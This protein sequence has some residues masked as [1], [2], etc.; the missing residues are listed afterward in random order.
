MPNHQQE[1]AGLVVGVADMAVGAAADG[2]ITTGSLGSCMAL[3][4]YDPVAGVG[5][6]LHFMLPQPNAKHD[7]RERKQFLYATT[8]IPYMLRR[9]GERG[10]DNANLVLVAAGG[11][12]VREGA[13]EMAIGKRNRTMLR[14]VL[15]KMNLKLAAED[16]GGTEARTMRLDLAT[17]AVQVHT[18]GQEL[19]LWEPQGAAPIG[20]G[21]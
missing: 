20:K 15:W 2:C 19:R 5:A 17:G 3:T 12:E 21:K 9:L 10:A 14:K 13:V 11:A 4:A 8:G 18:A 1:L 7:P 6:L 16:T